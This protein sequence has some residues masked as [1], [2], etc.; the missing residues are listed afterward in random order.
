MPKVS[1]I[2]EVREMDIDTIIHAYK[3]KVVDIWKGKR[4]VGDEG[5]AWS[6]QNCEVQDATKNKIR[7]TFK[8]RD[9]VPV[10]V[11]G[12]EIQILAHQGKKGWSGIYASD[13]EYKGKVNR[14]VWVTKSAEVIIGGKTMGESESAE[15]DEPQERSAAPKAKKTAPT[16]QNAPESHPEAGKGTP[17][18]D[19]EPVKQ[20]S[21]ASATDP[22]VKD[23]R[24]H[25][26]KSSNCMLQCIKAAAYVAGTSADKLGI[27]LSPD[28]F[29]AITSSFWISSDRAGLIDALPVKPIELTPKE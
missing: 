29:Q 22:A 5:A 4:G 16:R 25:L 28:Q 3:G 23:L 20:T 27:T 9:E 15:P 21:A 17:E 6:F 2:E 1:T 26:A 14:I 7:V 19:Y 18:S 12:K 10:N 13:D 8:D 24:Q 11:K